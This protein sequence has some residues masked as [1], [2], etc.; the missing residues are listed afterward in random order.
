MLKYLEKLENGQN[1]DKGKTN[2]IE[3][4]W[5]IYRYEVCRL[6]EKNESTSQ[7]N[8]KSPPLRQPKHIHRN[9]RS[10]ETQRPNKGMYPRK[11]RR[12]PKL[13]RLPKINKHDPLRTTL[14]KFNSP[15]QKRETFSQLFAGFRLRKMIAYQKFKC[16]QGLCNLKLIKYLYI[17]AS[18]SV[19]T[20]TVTIEEILDDTLWLSKYCL[21]HF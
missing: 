3:F 15:L 19:F 2:K 14:S 9:H 5:F 11:S 20:S 21:F 10:Q 13:Y 1:F 4:Y 12:R 8:F 7:S 18:R 16:R 6:F 17:T